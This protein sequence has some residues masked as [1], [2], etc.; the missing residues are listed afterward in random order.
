MNLNHP[1]DFTFTHATAIAGATSPWWLHNMSDWAAT[2]LPI[3][4][5][6]WL[7]LQAGVYIYKTFF[8]K[9]PTE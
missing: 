8:K 5:L 2:V 1:E 7:L 9:A 4:G 6:A 3:A